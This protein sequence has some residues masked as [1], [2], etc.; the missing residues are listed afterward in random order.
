MK[1]AEPERKVLSFSEK[2]TASYL[3]YVVGVSQAIL[4]AAMGASEECIAEAC[5]QV[6][7]ALLPDAGGR[8]KAAR[9][10]DAEQADKVDQDSEPHARAQDLLRGVPGPVVRPVGGGKA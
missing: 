3:F 4:A 2:L 8:R 7:K 10:G 1:R 6:R 9:N 5:A